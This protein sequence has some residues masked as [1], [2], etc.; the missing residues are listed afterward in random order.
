MNL[1]TTMSHIALTTVATTA[2]GMIVG[3]SLQ[4]L[5][6]ITLLPNDPDDLLSPIGGLILL[7]A[8]LVGLSTWIVHR[9]QHEGRR[10]AAQVFG[11][12]FGVMFFMTQIE[13]LAFN[14]AIHMPLGVVALGVANG[15]SMI[16]VVAAMS[17]RLR[18]RLG[19]AP[20]SAPT[21]RLGVSSTAARFTGLAVLYVVL[22][23]LFGYFIAWQFP[24][25]REYYA[26]STELVSF[27]EQMGNVLAADAWLVPFQIVRGYAWAALAYL[28][29]RGLP[30]AGTVE[31]YLL[32]GLSLSLPLA[33]PLLVPQGYMPWAVRLGHSS[34][35]FV[36]NFLFGCIALA[37]LRV[38]RPG[39]P[40][41]G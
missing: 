1:E 2:T 35:V 23:F 22:Y 24:A 27:T 29:I 9:S 18:R 3:G 17:V 21:A 20:Q 11:V 4:A 16:A 14:D 34:E 10:L 5:G 33:A 30:A 12:L 13:T 36:E 6:S 15:F 31:R 41:T 19:P 26:G 32:V 7:V 25:V 37:M 40:T 39:P 8:V 38:K 28:L